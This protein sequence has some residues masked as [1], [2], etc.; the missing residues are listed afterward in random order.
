MC[1]AVVKRCRRNPHFNSRLCCWYLSIEILS[2]HQS[3]RQLNEGASGEL[4]FTGSRVKNIYRERKET[5]ERN[6][7]AH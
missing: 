5:E 1:N 6:A 7:S 4:K 3:N 2:R